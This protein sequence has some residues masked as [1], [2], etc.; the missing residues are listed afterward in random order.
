MKPTA[1]DYELGTLCDAA[2]RPR[3]A[4]LRAANRRSKQRGM[5]ALPETSALLLPGE[6]FVHMHGCAEPLDLVF[7]ARDGRLLALYGDVQPGLRIRGRIGAVACLELP[8][9]QAALL[10]LTLGE[11]LRFAAA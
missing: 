7:L 1:N 2:G 9:G 5:R 4:C 11:T 8:A 6:P 10:G 3:V